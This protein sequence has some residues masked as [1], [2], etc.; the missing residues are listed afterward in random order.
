[1]NIEIMH[2]SQKTDRLI[3]LFFS[4]YMILPSYFALEVNESLPLLTASRV[5]LFFCFAIIILRKNGRVPILKMDGTLK[6]YF[7]LFILVNI[8]HIFDLKT[9]SLNPFLSILLEQFGVLWLI[10]ILVNTRHKFEKSVGILMYS[11]AA[12]SVI[13][14]LGF[15]FNTNFFYIL[16]TVSRTLT[17]AGMTD[18]GYRNGLL[19]VEAGFGHPVYYGMYCSI[20]IFLCLYVYN[21]KNLKA[22]SFVCLLLNIISLLLTNSRGSILAV[23]ITFLLTF[24]ING[25][26]ERKKYLKIIFGAILIVA[27][28]FVLSSKI[29]DYIIGVMQSIF[30][31]F[32][33]SDSIS[34]NYGANISFTSDRL[35][36][37]T[38][39]I[40][41]L[42][43]KPITGFGYGAQSTG[44]ISYYNRGMWFKTTTFD[45]GYV[46]I[47][48]CYGIIGFI[49]C[50]FLVKNIIKNLKYIKNEPYCIMFRNIFIV[51]LL[52]LLSVVNIDK[53]FWVILGLLLAYIRIVKLE[54]G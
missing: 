5:I 1:M 51:Y 45:V 30:I 23:I 39:I 50:L 4:L 44:L 41:T 32:G 26:K 8:F 9:S 46:E 48:C 37:F 2:K 20:M 33:L 52:C 29:R 14:I 17:Q 35:M 34:A 22:V 36:Q 3:L 38:G 28:L 18:I 40:W 53:I 25:K 19:R 24:F 42:L 49:A 13:S 47:F 7:S 10:M 21:Y 12:V 54:R 11:S 16:K 27:I 31:Y 43:H 6:T 15:I